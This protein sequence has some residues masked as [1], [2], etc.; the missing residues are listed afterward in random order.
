MTAAGQPLSVLPMLVEASAGTG[1]THAITTYFVQALLER[2]LKAEQILVVT[3]TKAATAELR[4]RT[5]RRI[6]EA[7][8]L[9]DSGAGTKDDLGPAIHQA[10]TRLGR[11][12]VRARLRRALHDLDR[13][14]IF[15]IHGFCQRL[16]QDHPLLFGVE[17]GFE[18]A[19]DSFSVFYDLAIDFWTTELHQR[20]SWFI[21]ALRKRRIDP[22]FLGRL[23]S[24]TLDP[25]VEILG[26]AHAELDPKALEEAMAA[27]REA[28]LAWEAG[29]D[30]ISQLLLD[31]AGLN[32]T[33]YPRSSIQ[34]KWLRELDS[35]FAKGSLE[36][37]EWFEKLGASRMVVKKGHGPPKHAFFEACDRLIDRVERVRLAVDSA[38]FRFLE[39]FVDRAR[40]E[41]TRRARVDAVL[42][43]DDLLTTVY[44]G[45]DAKASAQVQRTFPF[46]LVDEFQDTDSVQYGIFKR[47]YGGH[48]AV[49]V[50]D[51]KQA[52]YSFRGADVF[53]YLAASE[54]VEDRRRALTVNRRSDPGMITAIEALFSNPPSPF[55]IDAIKFPEVTAH[56]APRSSLDPSIEVIVLDRESAKKRAVE[57]SVPPIVAN[58]VALLLASGETIGGRPITPSDI[59]ILCRTNRQALCVTEALRRLELPVSLDGD[60]SVLGTSTADDVEAVLQ[61]ALTPA[62]GSAVRRAL[63]TG[64]VGMTPE[65]LQGLANDDWST[66][67]SRFRSWHDAWRD[68]GVT[69]FVEDFLRT[70]EAEKRL[71][72]LPTARRRLT[73]LLHIEEL[74]L[75]GERT[76]RR[77]PVALML[78]FRR[79]RQGSPEDKSVA[80]EDL[81]QRPDADGNTIRV[82]TVHKSKGLEYGVVYCPFLWRDATLFD[83]ERRVV[84]F[85]DP[86]DGHR[87]KCD[88]GS[89]RL[90]QHLEL[91]RDEA[92]SEA[93]RLLYV[94]VTRAKH[95]CTLFWGLAR[96][97][98]KSSF[99]YLLHGPTLPKNVTDDEVHASLDTLAASSRGTL[100]WTTPSPARARSRS[101]PSPERT[102]E[103]SQARR[104]FDPNHRIASFTSLTGRHDKTAARPDDKA[105]TESTRTLFR[106]LP[107]G[108][109]TGLLLHSLLE[110]APF[111]A[112]ESA[113]TLQLVEAEL[114]AYGYEASH[115]RR[116]LEDLRVVVGHP[117]FEADPSPT[118]SAI[119]VDQ[120]LR[121]LAFTLDSGRPDFG[122]LAGLL[123]SEGAPLYATGYPDHLR[124]EAPRVLRKFLRGFIDLVFEWE[125][126]WYV[127]DYKSNM[128]TGY[129]KASLAD[130]AVQS[131]Y[132][133]Q[134]LLYSVATHRY[135]AQRLPGYDPNT[136][137]GGA[138]LLFVR[139]MTGDGGGVYFDPMSPA[140]ITAAD[141]WLGGVS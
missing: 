3:Y 74:L 16:L 15:T 124:R 34:S 12:E 115:G 8:T 89:E 26:P 9:A 43:Y 73:D 18:V 106:E 70:T 57:E 5:R 17:T 7:F 64:L 110:Q 48:A 134:V 54:D 129:D 4:I 128:L 67:I 41:A 59:A 53:S 100:G 82:T 90:E 117:L 27:L 62:D 51:P 122:E 85:H 28:G 140:L 76:R 1:K 42:T 131:H 50:G 39:R 55:A 2:D 45:L 46:A 139:G 40:S 111:D 88:L 121:E 71:A 83:F 107:G 38:V 96:D 113:D 138:M 79:L 105:S 77:D 14:P 126:R 132:L 35:V 103:A 97:W 104:A 60:S 19:E 63:L 21:E 95:R 81:Q 114:R 109:R 61:A 75:R 10:V 65:E 13:A 44:R 91:C 31:H 133:L 112:L 72:A 52:I 80:Y 94:G 29:R 37:P 49:F 69:R 119:S 127:A 125:G 68:T 56:H 20:P 137:W 86:Q 30:A 23:A 93:L 92:L 78:W 98:R 108:A 32:R 99:A 102:L 130:A 66:W 33:R 84:K 123:E 58:E 118:L 11:D 101:A 22:E 25:T 135:L 47:I 141:R 136:N 116:V 36:L 87:A 120:Q 24:A 6:A